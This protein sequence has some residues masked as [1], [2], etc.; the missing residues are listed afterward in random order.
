MFDELP[1]SGAERR[2][3]HTRW[4]FLV[5]LAG[6]LSALAILLVIPMT[7]VQELPFHW[8]MMS[9]I[10]PPPPGAPPPAANASSQKPPPAAD[11]MTIPPF[12]P[13]HARIIHESPP[14]PAGPGTGT[15]AIPGAIPGLGNDGRLS[16][17][18]SPGNPAPP[19]PSTPRAVTI[20]GEVQSAKLIHMVQPDYPLVARASYVQG[21][22]V[23]A[24]TIAKDGTVVAVRY[25]SGPVLLVPAVEKAVRKWRYRPTMLNGRP[26]EVETTIKVIFTLKGK[27]R[28]KAPKKP[29]AG[30]VPSDG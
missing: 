3:T 30:T 15:V 9:L 10:P 8:R 26:V 2:P 4:T 18:F 28:G 6:Q 23:V 12:I 19:A 16:A 21:A 11:A 22:V 24:A 13:P 27:H 5:S 29:R 17:I 25:I 20:G 7:Y 14:A 1:I